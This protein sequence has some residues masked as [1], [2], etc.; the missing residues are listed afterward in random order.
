M[1]E[2][3]IFVSYS[4]VPQDA[5]FTVG[6]HKIINYIDTNGVHRIIEA[7]PEIT[8]LSVGARVAGLLDTIF[9]SESGLPSPFGRIVTSGEIIANP[10]HATYAYYD[11]AWGDDLSSV[12]RQIV[13]FGREVNAGNYEYRPLSQNSNTFVDEALRRAGLPPTGDAATY[14]NDPAV[15]HEFEAP[16]SG[17]PLRHRFLD[18]MNQLGR[19]CFPAGTAIT[20]AE[21]TE[22]PIEQVR[23]GDLVL[24]FDPSAESGRG[25]LTPRRVTRLFENVTQEWLVLTTE[26]GQTL[27]VT[28]G[29]HMLAADGTFRRIDDILAGD[30]LLVWRD[31]SLLG[32]TAERVTYSAETAHLYEE[33]EQVSYALSGNAAL[34]PEVT[35]G[36]RTYNFEVEGLHTYVA[37]GVRVHN[38]SWP[39]LVVARD[40]FEA[41]FGYEFTGSGAD[42]DLL[43]G[44]IV[45]GRIE[46]YGEYVGALSDD[47]LAV[48]A[49]DAIR[50][51][52]EGDIP[53]LEAGDL[54]SFQVRGDRLSSLDVRDGRIDWRDLAADGGILE[55][56]TIYEEGRVVFGP[57]GQPARVEHYADG[58]LLE[59]EEWLPDGSY[60][61]TFYDEEGAYDGSL[62]FDGEGKLLGDAGSILPGSCSAAAIRPQRRLPHSRGMCLPDV[63]TTNRGQ[64]A[65]N[66]LPTIT[67]IA[68]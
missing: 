30:G 51:K 32:V 12:W 59:T 68:A 9:W 20:L 37:G 67:G 62:T 1:A 60:V 24:A 35:R 2:E 6:Y 31:G 38:E 23:P 61:E 25:A 22:R 48:M 55:E 42:I 39:T 13:D 58:E 18:N 26:H 64:V 41:K 45:N 50:G 3:R 5:S 17:M 19:E 46:A 40:E 52:V 44:G 4:R 36:W 29:H 54:I 33:A 7:T 53:N 8:G 34:K 14:P 27:T 21:G 43:M 63:N 47:R 66:S 16:G 49:Y 10:V 65:L 15:V 56:T 28:P 11:L 57:D